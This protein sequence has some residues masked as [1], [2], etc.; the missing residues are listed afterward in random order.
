MNTFLNLLDNNEG[1]RHARR[2]HGTPLTVADY[3]A[4]FQQTKSRIN[5]DSSW[6]LERA[7]HF[8]ETSPG[9]EALRSG[10][11]QGALRLMEEGRAGITAQA[12]QDTQRGHVF[13]RLRV[14]EEPLTPYMQWELTTLAV[15]A[16]CGRPVRVLDHAHIAPTEQTVGPLPELV[17]LGTEVLYEV[18]YTGRGVHQGAIAYTDP[19]AI[20][21]VRDY[22]RGLYEHPAA[23]DI[24][25]Y[26]SRSVQHLPPPPAA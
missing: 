7:Q 16:E 4:H 24:G 2:P 1:P 22:I 9:R 21:A 26:V 25:P 17:V 13:H 6:K 23:R 14:V 10:D 19:D 12:A 18:R 15:R 5:G 20:H 11:W 8:E 3:S